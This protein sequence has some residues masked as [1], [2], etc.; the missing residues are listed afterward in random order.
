VYLKVPG[1]KEPVE[2]DAIINGVLVDAKA[3][4]EIKPRSIYDLTSKDPFIHEMSRKRILE[5][6]DRQ[7]RAASHY[8]RKIEWRIADPRM[9]DAVAEFF[10]ETQIPIAVRHVP[11]P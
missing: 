1:L 2:F 7:L 6:A 8:G 11:A 4:G 10:A 9:A 3:A 5:Q